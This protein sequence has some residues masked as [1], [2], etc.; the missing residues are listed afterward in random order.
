MTAAWVMK[1]SF[2]PPLVTVSI[3]P[4]R[5]TYELIARSGYFSLNI[6]AEGQE[7]IARHFGFR[8]GRDTDKLQGIAWH[9]GEKTGAP[10]LDDVSAWVECR[11]IK[12]IEVGDHILFVGE[13]INS[14]MKGEFTP[15]L[16]RRKDYYG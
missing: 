9:K 4:Q 6:L 15:L 11:V 2:N 7:D 5:Y 8:S 13:I 14:R 10:I 12:S 3:S 1:A 16:Y